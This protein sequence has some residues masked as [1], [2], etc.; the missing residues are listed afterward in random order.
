MS[1]FVAIIGDNN[2][3]D[4]KK[5]LAAIMHRG[6]D[7]FGV[8]EINPAVVGQNYLF[9]DVKG[10]PEKQSVP[11][12]RPQPALMMVGYDGEIGGCSALCRQFNISR[13]PFQQEYLILELFSRFNTDMFSYLGD[14]IFAFVIVNENN[15]VLAARDLSGIKSLFYA[16]KD[17]VIYLGSETKAL[18]PI[19]DD[20][21][22][23]PA[24]H[25]MDESGK[26]TPFSC[27]S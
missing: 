12:V 5:M 25:Y 26:F 20:I 4:C 14:S 24:G 8:V 23:F 27:S 9:A 2:L 10:P 15:G 13:T 17:H 7:I 21:Y 3:D 19:R 16:K 1:G 18:L 6:P 22:E 11:V